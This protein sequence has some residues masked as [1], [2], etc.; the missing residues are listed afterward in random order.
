M[1]VALTPAQRAMAAQSWRTSMAGMLERRAGPRKLA[2]E[3]RVAPA[4]TWFPAS[5]GGSQ[6][7]PTRDRF[8]PARTSTRPLP[9][10]D[11]DIAYA[12]VTG[13]AQWIQSR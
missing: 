2:I 12:S 6:G 13:L 7:R 10:K 11:E 5:I 4:T 1:Q 8:V 9:V 3:D